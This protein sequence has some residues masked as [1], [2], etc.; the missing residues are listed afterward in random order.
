M[1]ITRT[2]KG[3]AN[4]KT[5]AL[6]L[7]V[8]SVQ[9]P[10]NTSMLVGV[11]Y[12]SG[13]GNP[14]M[15][16]GSRTWDEPRVV[17]A[18]LGIRVALF[19]MYNNGATATNDVVVSW[20]TTAPTAKAMFVTNISEV[21]RRDFT[22]TNNGSSDAPTSGALQTTSFAEEYLT[23]LFVSE[24][25]TSDA[26]GTPVLSY[27]SGQRDGTI[28]GAVNTNITLHETYKITTATEDTRA[29]KTGATSRDWVVILTGLKPI[30]TVTADAR[31]VVSDVQ[32]VSQ[33]EADTLIDNDILSRFPPEYD[34]TIIG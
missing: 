20:D 11:G 28:G 19:L 16:W 33:A 26:A 2:A 29:R 4:D 27:L 17:E 13:E 24:G 1:A 31:I 32:A 30:Y 15:D 25:P 18:A 8:P 34:V 14:S 3:T 9:I 7:T 22:K 6:T 23:G 12:D 21:R 5:G 10:K